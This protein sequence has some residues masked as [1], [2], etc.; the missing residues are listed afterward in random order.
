MLLQ[1]YD[2]VFVIS[3]NVK[4]DIHIL[5]FVIYNINE[6]IIKT[7]MCIFSMTA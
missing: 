7:K 3:N 4:Y 1:I 2:F 6:V 5:N